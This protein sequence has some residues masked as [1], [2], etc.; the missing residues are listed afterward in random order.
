MGSAA[1]CRENADCCHGFRGMLYDIY[2]CDFC[3]VV[4]MVVVLICCIWTF[5]VSVVQRFETDRAAEMLFEGSSAD[6]YASQLP[7][8]LRGVYWMAG[9]TFPELMVA[10]QAGSWDPEARRMRLR[11]GV[12]Y[13][14]SYDSSAAG[15]WEYA[16]VQLS[17][18]FGLSCLDFEFNSNF[19]YALLPFRV[20]V[21][22]VDTWALDQVT[23]DGNTWTRNRFDS[24]G[25]EEIEY[26]IKRVIS[27]GGER[28]SAFDEMVRTTRDDIEVRNI[29][30]IEYMNNSMSSRRKTYVQLVAG[31]PGGVSALVAVVLSLVYL[32]CCAVCARR[33]KTQQRCARSRVHPGSPEGQ[34]PAMSES[35]SSEGEGAHVVE[36]ARA[37]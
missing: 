2:C 27:A 25:V 22:I 1:H 14:W 8:V 6:L 37:P 4:G 20:F 3:C 31:R 35:H 33:T 21:V 15:W 16:L 10:F 17:W 23:A 28:L 29:P 26:T 11:F 24:N 7:D 9:N 30:G 19:T 34:H 18:S 32:G 5:S 12:P 36:Q 13:S